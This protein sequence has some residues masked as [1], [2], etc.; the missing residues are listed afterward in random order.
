MGGCDVGGPDPE[1]AGPAPHVVGVFVTATDG[2]FASVAADG[3]TNAKSTT[4]IAVKFD[5][6]MEPPTVSR[7]GV[8]LQAEVKEVRTL[9][10]CTSPIGLSATYDPV[11]RTATYYLKDGP[12]PN[13]V[14]QLTVLNRGDVFGFA[15]FDGVSLDKNYTF[16]FVSNQVAGAL[17]APPT[18]ALYCE[19]PVGSTCQPGFENVLRNCASCH[20]ETT[21]DG[22]SPL[23][24]S[25]GMYLT[26][27]G[28]AATPF[29][30]GIRETVVGVTAHQTE[31]GG[32]AQVTAENPDRFGV[33]M[34]RVKPGEPGNSYLLYKILAKDGLITDP[35]LAPGEADRLRLGVVSG[36]PMPP[37]P[38]SVDMTEEDAGI[39]SAWIAAGAQVPDCPK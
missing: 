3:S 1:P 12:L 13:G 37:L 32:R 18:A 16:T 8:C 7:Q 6:Y 9:A 25:M 28:S 38:Y 34:A 39:V 14:V 21:V 26:F 11:S 31:Q 27:E 15:A 24:A 17:E 33:S 2:S 35:T 29:A 23:A 36:Q 10:D 4:R 5:R 30:A 19:C 20:Q 22:G